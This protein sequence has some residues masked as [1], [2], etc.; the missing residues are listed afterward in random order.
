M[1]WYGLARNEEGLHRVKE[2]RNILHKIKRKR[3]N[4]I[5]YILRGRCLHRVAIEGNRR[6]ARQGSRCKPLLD[7][8]RERGTY[9]NLKHETLQSTLWRTCV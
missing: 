3:A 9:R 4:W 7:D 5:G 6:D 2:G 1:G 8:L